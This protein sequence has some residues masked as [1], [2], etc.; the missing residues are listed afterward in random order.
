HKL[1]LIRLIDRGTADLNSDVDLEIHSTSRGGGPTSY[2]ST[3]VRDS[4]VSRSSCQNVSPSAS[5]LA[6]V[7]RPLHRMFDSPSFGAVTE[8]HHVN[9]NATE[10]IFTTYRSEHFT[11]LNGF[12][13]QV[14]SGWSRINVSS[15]ETRAGGDFC[16]P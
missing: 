14:E 13:D 9:G 10:A 8:P 6:S 1:F 15:F 5:C 11:L 3:R 2:L 4:H 7:I 16:L 12:F